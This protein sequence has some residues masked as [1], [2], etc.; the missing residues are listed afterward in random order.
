MSF[1]EQMFK[2]MAK[3]G[4]VPDAVYAVNWWQVLLA[5]ASLGIV[6]VLVGVAIWTWWLG[7]LGIVVVVAGVWYLLMVG[8]RVLQWRWLRREAGL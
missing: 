2:L 5:D 1:N 8:R 3:H 6:A 7:W 4:K